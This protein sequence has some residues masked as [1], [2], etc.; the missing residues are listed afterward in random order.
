MNAAFAVVDSIRCCGEHTENVELE[1]LEIE[2]ERLETVFF[3]F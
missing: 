1:S 3:F 2:L